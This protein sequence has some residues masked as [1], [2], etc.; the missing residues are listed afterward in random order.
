MD[1][2]IDWVFVGVEY[3]AKNPSKDPLH[4]HGQVEEVVLQLLEIEKGLCL[5]FVY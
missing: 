4:E 2:G 3:Y 1:I 5:S